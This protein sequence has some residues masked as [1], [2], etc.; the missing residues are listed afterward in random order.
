VRIRPTVRVRLTLW[1]AS[2]FFVGGAV[3]LLAAYFIVTRS[4]VGFGDR[5]AVE[6]ERRIRESGLV[7]APDPVALPAPESADPAVVAGIDRIY[8]EVEEAERAE[9]RARIGT[10]FGMV[11]GLATLGSLAAGYVVAGRALRPVARITAAARRVGEGALDERIGLQGPADEL[12]ELA[13]TFD[14]MLSRIEAALQSQRQF[15]ANASHELRT[16]LTL[17]RT[18]IDV[19]LESPEG[20]S[21]SQ[22]KRMVDTLRDAIERSDQ[23]TERLLILARSDRG[24]DQRRETDLAAVARSVIDRTETPGLELRGDLRAA[25][26]AGDQVLLERAIVNL[27]EN[28][29]RYN[30]SG[31]W[32]SIRTGANGDGSWLRVA[33]S[34]LADRET[35]PD[36][37]FRPFRRSPA[38]RAPGGF[39]L[40]LSIVRSVAVAHGGSTAIRVG[41]DRFEVSMNLPRR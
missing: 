25:P 4:L 27:L 8:E 30:V 15:V 29:V 38:A 28:A 16:P 32:I 10:R 2:I 34:A 1:Y 12:K 13:D 37:L 41:A 39:G 7:D 18:A 26:V 22:G 5:V 3:L 33:N 35:D 20:L 19:T 11:L 40:G 9:L 23:L 24:L 21:G 36:E 14:V 31:G 17:M 6:A